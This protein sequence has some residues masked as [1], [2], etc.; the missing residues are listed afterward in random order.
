[1][2]S[3]DYEKYAV[4]YSDL[5]IGGTYYLAF[6]D[7]PDLLQQYVKGTRALDYGCGPGRSTRFL[8]SLGFSTV[9]VDIS[10]DMLEQARLRD[11]SGEYHDIQSGKI[12]FE[13]LSFDLI[14]S[15]FVFIEISSLDEIEKILLEMKRV[16][17]RDGYIVIVTSP[18]ES[19]NANLVSFSYNFPENRK[20][21]QSGETVKLLIKGT[22][23]ILYDYY[24][25]E[26]NYQQVFANV[27]L[28]ITETLK[29]LGYEEDPVEWLDETKNS[30]MLIYLL[31]KGT[32]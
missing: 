25:T 23:V 28:N 10:H 26:Q 5:D 24:W 13:D 32:L 12:P 30:P 29:P 21:I 1:M 22:N 31:R 3:H 19:Y 20:P 9:G 16:L 6:R 4:E 18:T 11:P 27:G 2:K 8:K 15:S 7:M 17:K 14:F